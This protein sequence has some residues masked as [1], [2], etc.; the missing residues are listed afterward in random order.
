MAD[1][2]R[3]AVRELTVLPRAPLVAAVAAL[4]YALWPSA[5]APTAAAAEQEWTAEPAVGGRPYVYLEGLPGTVLEDRVSVTN[6]GARPLTVRLSTTGTKW[7]AFAENPVTVPARTRADVPF[8]MTVPASAAPGDRSARIV[9]SADGREVAVPVHVRVGGPELAALTVED[10][11]VDGDLIRY[12]LVN[13]G[14][15]VLTPRLSVRAV[16][17]TGEL[18]RRP[19]RALSVEL[20]PGRRLDLTEPWPDRP[21][22]DSVDI[23][24]RATAPGAEPAEATVSALYVRWGPV[25]AGVLGLGAAA[26]CLALWRARARPAPHEPTGPERHLAQAGVQR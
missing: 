24:L 6:R 12:T 26:G 1:P 21:A 19:A 8:A 22:L 4:L 20:G 17:L 11:R 16:G 2:P 10:V 18:L 25:I 13:R 3:A 7:L 9:A 5:Q 15:T 14:N 23:T